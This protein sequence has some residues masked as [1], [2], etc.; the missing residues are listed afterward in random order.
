MPGERSDVGDLRAKE[1]EIDGRL[2]ETRADIEQAF[3][4][5]TGPF[6]GTIHAFSIAVGASKA[7]RTRT[8]LRFVLA[9][10]SSWKSASR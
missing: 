1:R 2:A 4:P 5:R 6:C 10:H 8:S 7:S 3:C 9:A